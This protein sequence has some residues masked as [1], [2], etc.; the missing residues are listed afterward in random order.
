MSRST[1]SS[2]R[3]WAAYAALPLLVATLAACGGG[4]SGGGTS[5]AAAAPTTSAAPVK[6]T[7]SSNDLATKVQAAVAAAKSAH[8][9]GS[10]MSDGTK[11][12]LDVAG[13]ADGTNGMITMNMGSQSFTIVTADGS[14]YVKASAAF[15]KAQL[16]TMDTT[17]LVDKWVK[18][19]ADKAKDL[20]AVSVGSLLTS[21]SKGFDKLGTDVKADTVNG[22]D[23]WVLTDA[24]GAAEGQ[25]FIDA[26]T[27]LPLKYTQSK[28]S[29]EIFF[30][31]WDAVT[32]AKAPTGDILNL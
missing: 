26:K 2:M 3:R 4:T 32:P 8:I 7:P 25:F 24:K 31:Q 29:S 30:S 12:S 14:T 6:T 23:V 13:T 18:V 1:H 9:T 27:S 16:P 17:R 15:W 21:M 22:V 20:S 11:M 28:D 10:G 5:N 19:P